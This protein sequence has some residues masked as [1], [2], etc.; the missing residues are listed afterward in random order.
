MLP[1]S[2]SGAPVILN[3]GSPLADSCV[4]IHLGLGPSVKVYAEA[5]TESAV[6]AELGNW[7][8]VLAT[9]G[10]WHRIATGPD[11]SCW[12]PRRC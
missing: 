1:F 6:V 2:E 11:E 3:P 5:A 4:A 10:G 9:E 8:I 7:A 12:K